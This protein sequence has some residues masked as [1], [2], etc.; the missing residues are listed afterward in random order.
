MLFERAFEL[1]PFWLPVGL[2]FIFWDM[3]VS[4]RR[5]LF[6]SKQEYALLEIK[7]PKDVFKSPLAMELVLQGVYVTFGESTWYDR[8]ILGKVRAWFSLE[9]VSIEGNI[10]FFI[11]TRKGF[12]QSVESRIYSQYPTAEV[13]EVPDYTADVPYAKTGSGWVLW[14]SEFKLAKGDPYPIK[15]YVDY[16]LDK[17]PKEEYK[18]D[19]I[20]PMLE[21]MGSIGRNE[22]V[23]FQILVRANKGKKDPTS[24]WKTAWQ[25]E[26]KKTIEDIMKQA[27]ERS[28]PPPEDGED[29]RFS[30]LTEGDR[31]AIKAIERNISKIGFDC[32][33]RAFYL[34]KEESFNGL[35]IPGLLG[36][37][38]Q[39]GSND[40]N[41]II[42][43]R[44]TQSDFPWQNYV[45]LRSDVK[46]F[47]FRGALV[48]EL[49]WK[50]FDAYRH[51]SWYFPPYERKPF[52]LNIEELATIFHFPGRV[53]ETPTFKRIES[54]KAEPPPN[55]PL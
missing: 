17:D 46:P 23:W 4:Y 48:E 11:W 5:A 24:H 9:I 44:V 38:R 43:Q 13:Y 3:W 40:L 28:G 20:T 26:G 8:Y 21:Y 16:N 51:R 39:Y 47:S 27:K 42:P 34:A 18:I 7:V 14:G 54:K 31:N 30:N 35:N 6:L 41:S 1:A 19:P 49:K 52:V 50:L 32:G 25:D 53:A 45:G 36:S 55:L 12:K 29:Y 37:L 22:Q 10:R 15:T 33:M 2:G